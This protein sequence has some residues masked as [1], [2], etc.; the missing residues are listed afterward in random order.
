MATR[1]THTDPYVR[2]RDVEVRDS[3]GPMMLIV[4]I[5]LA[6]AI[7]VG[8]WFAFNGDGTNDGGTTINNENTEQVTPGDTS[9]GTTGDTG[10]TDGGTTDG[11]TTTNP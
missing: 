10:T 9:D 8:A 3:S 1:H 2:E 7:A 6:A 11:G 4:G 5:I